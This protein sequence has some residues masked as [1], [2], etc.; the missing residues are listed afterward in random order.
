VPFVR[1]VGYCLKELGVGFI[2]SL[3]VDINYFFCEFYNTDLNATSLFSGYPVYISVSPSGI[4]WIRLPTHVKPE[5]LKLDIID[6]YNI[7]MII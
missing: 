2:F 7:F 1:N 4:F 6:K 5:L 3:Y